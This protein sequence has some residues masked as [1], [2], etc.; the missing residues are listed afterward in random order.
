MPGKIAFI[1]PGQGA[2]MAGMGQDFYEQSPLAKEVYDEAQK[3]MDF[4]LLSICFGQDARLDETAYT[5]PALVAT[6][7]AIT[8]VLES[9][10]ITPDVTA[11]LSLGEYSAIAAAG[12]LDVQEAIA[13][14]RKRG[15]Y[16]EQAVPDHS[17]AMTAA[18]GFTGEQV[19]EVITGI[20][21]VWIANY[22]CPGQI[23]LTG[24]QK[25]VEQAEVKLKEAGMKRTIRLKVSGPFHSPMMKEAGLKLQERLLHT[26][27]HSLQCPYISNVTA[28][29]VENEAEIKELLVRQM[30][31]SVLWEQSVRT[32]IAEGVDTFFEIGPGRTLS[33]FIRKIDKS[34]TCYQIGTVQELEQVA[35]EFV[36]KEN[37]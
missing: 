36:C 2:Q 33:N 21:D 12:G 9:K 35:G 13:L 27:V 19:E 15:C 30:T 24:E 4:D 26:K 34:V 29:R 7:L 25:A 8:K 11:G 31:S 10:G 1:Y 32:M 17:G 28:K 16:M 23:V 18:I 37:K 6:S 5:Q 22:N 14:V 3:N 20:P